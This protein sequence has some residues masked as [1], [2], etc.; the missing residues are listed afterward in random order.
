[1][2]ETMKE[3]VHREDDTNGE[4]VGF[5]KEDL[6]ILNIMKD[7]EGFKKMQEALE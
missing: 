1:M 5:D 7:M 4:F 2:E 6:N 3:E